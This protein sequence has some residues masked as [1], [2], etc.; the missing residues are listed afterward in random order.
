MGGY[1]KQLCVQWNQNCTNLLSMSQGNQNSSDCVWRHQCKFKEDTLL[2]QR[3]I[4]ASLHD[5]KQFVVA[6][7]GIKYALFCQIIWFWIFR[8]KNNCH[9]MHATIWDKRLCDKSLICVYRWKKN[10]YT[11]FTITEYMILTNTEFV[12]HTHAV[13]QMLVLLDLKKAVTIN[14]WTESIWS[15][16]CAWQ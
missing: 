13:A 14:C 11:L 16:I 9:I 10:I 5:P 4:I 15:A 1:V 6:T 8:M 2:W 7:Y 12:W 3:T